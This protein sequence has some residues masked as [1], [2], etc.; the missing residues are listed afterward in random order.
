MKKNYW[1]VIIAIIVIGLIAYGIYIKQNNSIKPDKN[2]DNPNLCKNLISF[3]EIK[4]ACKTGIKENTNDSYYITLA[5]TKIDSIGSQAELAEGETSRC[6]RDIVTND[7]EPAYSYTHD[8][9][10]KGSELMIVVSTLDSTDSA[11]KFY[12]ETVISFNESNPSEKETKK[13]LILNQNTSEFG[14][15]GNI[16]SFKAMDIFDPES[17]TT[18]HLSKSIGISFLKGTKVI[19][20]SSAS[21]NQ[22]TP[23][24]CE[25]DNLK[26]IAKIID[27][28][29]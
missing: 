23:L 13:A 6:L 8:P 1:I 5:N 19:W 18:V 9:T 27:N 4:N 15:K 26:K 22:T 29:I 21:Y 17:N 2:S 12:E 14:I 3:D 11:N 24:L 7:Y 28:K 16:G 25:L 20:L 10:P